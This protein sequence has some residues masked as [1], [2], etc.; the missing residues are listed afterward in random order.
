VSSPPQIVLASIGT[1]GDIYPFLGLGVELRARGY[2]VTLAASE[3]FANRA[4]NAGIG[5]C[6][7][8]S[9]AEFD[10]VLT[11]TDFWHPIKG[12]IMLARWGVR[13]LRRQYEVLS[14]LVA[15]KPTMLVANP[16]VLAARLIQEKPG[17]P[18]VSVVL[19]PWMIPSLFAPPVMMGGL[20]LP[21]WTPRAIGETY[22]RALD[23][24]GGLLVG[25]ELNRLRASLGLKRV[26]RIFQWWFSPELVIGMFPEWYGEPQRDWP[27]QVKLAGFP[28]NDNQPN[29]GVAED[30]I[31]FCRASSAPIVFTFG[32]G[33]M[34]AGELFQRAIEA[35]SMLG[36]RAIFL[37]KFRSQLPRD[38]PPFV[39]HCD[40]APFRELFPLCAAVVHHG[41]IGTVSKALAAGRPQLILPFAYD[42]MDNALRV[43][44]LRAGDWLKPGK[45][46]SVAIAAALKKVIEPQVAVQAQTVAKRFNGCSGLECAADLIDKFRSDRNSS[47]G[48]LI[49]AFTL[50]ELLVVIA[51]IAILAA[52]LLPALAK[53][54]ESPRRTTCVSNLRQIVL[55]ALMYADE[56]QDQFPAQ[57]GD[58]LPVR[59]VGG[60]GTNYYDVLMPYVN[61]PRVWLCPSAQSSPGSLVAFHMN[62]LIITTNG[63]QAAAI[64]KPSQTLLIAETGYRKLYDL[65][66]LRPDQ[67]G[68]YLYDRPQRNHFGGSNAGFVDGHVQWYHDSQWDSN[69]FRAIP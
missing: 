50:I 55:G 60:N 37:T 8:L 52:L 58:G 21:R 33:M 10:E 32:S 9:S 66:Y 12:P 67:T 34:H 43:K 36:V 6:Q 49:Q 44:R 15:T 45:R 64:A 39:H 48:S 20:T 69:S 2:D 31:Q 62:G 1:D 25:R 42:Q 51:I 23:G 54:K 16:G 47:R 26:R 5:F 65:A 29:G 57:P 4:A 19:Q 63:L 22:F 68:N 61:N 28:L 41:G 27:R 18:L 3:H 56:H 7:F 59:A 38:L 30:T 46:S 40:F 13:L 14:A 24:L 53:G 11:R 17:V 35:C